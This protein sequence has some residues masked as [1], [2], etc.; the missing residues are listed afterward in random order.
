[1]AAAAPRGPHQGSV[2]FEDVAI[3]FSQEEWGLLDEAQRFL[4]HDVML[5]IFAL[6]ASLA[7][8]CL[9]I[10]GVEQRM[11]YLLSRVFL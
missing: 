10:V 2:T 1:M 9:Q 3:Y 7:F 11:R 4:Y 5:E 6:T 8:L